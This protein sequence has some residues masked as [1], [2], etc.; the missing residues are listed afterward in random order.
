MLKLATIRSGLVALLALTS[1]VALSACGGGESTASAAP[2]DTGAPSATGGSASTNTGLTTQSVSLSGSPATSA[3][4]GVPYSFAPAAGGALQGVTFSIA[5]KP[6]WAMFNIVTG[7]LTGTPTAADVGTYGNISI[8]AT[9]SA[10]NASLPTFSIV[11]Q[12]QTVASPATATLSWTPPTQ[13]TD[14]TSVSNLAGYIIY[15]G[16]SADDLTKVVQ[17][18]NPGLTAYTIGDLGTGTHYFS[19]S[20][21]TSAGT[22]SALSAVG[23]KTV[24]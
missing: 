17:I 13:N 3:R 23:S 1:A 19:I 10:S 6:G 22:E 9:T 7:T 4:V 16:S 12:Q 20:A 11:V 21:Y 8:T 15:Q 18:T 24:M 5:N 2:A 14:G